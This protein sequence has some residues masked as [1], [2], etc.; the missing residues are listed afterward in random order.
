MHEHFERSP[1]RG[2]GPAQRCIQVRPGLGRIA[3]MASFAPATGKL[4]SIWCDAEPP[5]AEHDRD[6]AHAPPFT[7]CQPLL[8]VKETPSER[9]RRLRNGQIAPPARGPAIC[10]WEIRGLELWAASHHG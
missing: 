10:A 2:N 8:R 7:L 3:G 9:P 4:R 5:L 1:G 6:N